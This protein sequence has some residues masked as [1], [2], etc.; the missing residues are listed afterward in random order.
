MADELEEKMFKARDAFDVEAVLAEMKKEPAA[1]CDALFRIIREKPSCTSEVVNSGGIQSVIAAMR[2][3]AG[4][5]EVQREGC[6][7]LW[8]ICRDGGMPASRVVINN[9]GYDVLEEAT[10]KFPEGS[11]T[12]EMAQLCLSALADHG[13]VSFAE[14]EGMGALMVKPEVKGKAFATVHIGPEPRNKLFGR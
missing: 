9:G 10:K 13:L 12:E 1:A 4:D 8:R 2:A 7:T 11:A 14:P 3:N 6:T 5:A